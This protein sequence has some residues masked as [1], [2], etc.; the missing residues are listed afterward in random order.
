MLWKEKKYKVWCDGRKLNDFERG[1]IVGILRAC[2]GTFA[3]KGKVIWGRYLS[4]VDFHV[5]TVDMTKE[6]Y[7]M[8]IKHIELLYP[9]VCRFQKV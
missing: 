6:R 3:G 7:K 5:F 4:D 2:S 1:Q 8:A 9:G